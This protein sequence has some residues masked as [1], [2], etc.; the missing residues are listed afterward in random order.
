MVSGHQFLRRVL[1]YGWLGSVSLAAFPASDRSSNVPD[2]TTTAT[3][4]PSPATDGVVRI[5]AADRPQD[6]ELLARTAAANLDL[7][8][9]LKSF[10]C[11]ERVER[12]KGH[13]NSNSVRQ[14]DTVT[15][16]LSFE[17]GAEHYTNI[18]QK[19]RSLTA[20]ANLSGAWSEGEFGTLLKQTGQLLSHEYV[21]FVRWGTIDGIPAAL[22]EFDVAA[23]NSPWDL[24][25]SGRHFIIPFHTEVWIAT[26][27]AQILRIMRSSLSIPPELHISEI[28]WDVTL[29]AVNLN[30][31]TWLLPRAAS[32]RVLY[33]E[34]DRREWNIMQFS[35]YHRY[36][37]EVALRFN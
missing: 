3:V 34:S 4:A 28:A 17:N 16:R 25:V 19:D 22:Y 14:L 30:D 32:Y 18:R 15:A 10:V 6:Q 9:N 5:G 1:L 26:S 33:C 20:L 35:D 21:S 36:G 31:R 2:G 23:E 24:Q 7:Y 29:Q 11:N 12:F 8:A 37:S 13:I 27:S